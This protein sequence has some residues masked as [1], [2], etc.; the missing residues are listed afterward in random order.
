M[1]GSKLKVTSIAFNW[2]LPFK[3]IVET[4]L[5]VREKPNVVVFFV[6]TFI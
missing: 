6:T 1:E 3:K 5:N 2:I 4:T